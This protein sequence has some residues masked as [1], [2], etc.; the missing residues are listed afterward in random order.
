MSVTVL[1]CDVVARAYV[2]CVRL[3]YNVWRYGSPLT[4]TLFGGFAAFCKNSALSR[5]GVSQS[6]SH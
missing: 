2:L 1:H 5:E 4:P 3:R 6:V